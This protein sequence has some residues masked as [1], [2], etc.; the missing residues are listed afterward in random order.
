MGGV[1]AGRRF[2]PV[3]TAEDGATG[4]GDLHHRTDLGN[5]PD[6]LQLSLMPAFEIIIQVIKDG[7]NLAGFPFRRT[8]ET[9]EGSDFN[10]VKANGDVAPVA[11]PGLIAGSALQLFVASSD[12]PVT[13]VPGGTVGADGKIVMGAG[14]LL[15]LFNTNE[16]A[17]SG[18]QMEIENAG[19]N[20]ANL[21]GAWGSS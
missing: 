5:S 9:N 7:V 19:A 10:I 20:P 12:Q 14:G 11:F 8:L 3:S 21:K 15:L 2:L 18:E 17:A 16:Q 1:L 13:F 6:L 4:A